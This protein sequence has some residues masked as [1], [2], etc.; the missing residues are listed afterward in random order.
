MALG[1]VPPVGLLLTCSIKCG[2]SEPQWFAAP[3]V[4]HTAGFL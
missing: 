2:H 3:F 1:A 4:L